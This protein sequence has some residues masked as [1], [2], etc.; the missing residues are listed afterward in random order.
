MLDRHDDCALENDCALDD[1]NEATTSNDEG[2]AEETFSS[3][4]YQA[5]FWS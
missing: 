3:R 4:D 2:E 5:G 1:Q